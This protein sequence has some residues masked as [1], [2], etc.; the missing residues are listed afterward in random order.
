MEWK[1]V[2]PSWQV[3]RRTTGWHCRMRSCRRS[4][5]STVSA[6]RGRGGQHR[7]RRNTA[8]RLVHEPT[9]M[10]GQATERRSQLQNRAEALQR[11]RRTMALELRRPVALDSYAPPLHTAADSA[12]RRADGRGALAGSDRHEA[13]GVLERGAA[14]A[15]P[16]RGAE[17]ESGGHGGGAGL[18]DESA[19]S[20]WSRVSRTCC[21]ESI[22]CGNSAALDLCE[23][24]CGGPGCGLKPG[25]R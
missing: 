5:G 16:V 15:G 17:Y 3:W 25:N 6:C 21:A 20:G 14:S 11:L 23:R 8:V 4:A 2:A 19:G 9:G 22:R 24:S 7:N 13:S 10:V 12:A 18:L 1:R